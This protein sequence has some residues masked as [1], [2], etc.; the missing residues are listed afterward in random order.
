VEQLGTLNPDILALNEISVPLQTGRWLQRE[1]KKR[2]GLTYAL[3]QQTKSSGWSMDEAQGLLTRFPIVETGNLD[4]LSR[5]RVAQ[6]TRLEIE[7]TNVDVYVTHLHHVMEEDGLRQYQVQ[8]LFE[9]V[10]GRRDA[11]AQIVCG[12]FNATPDA[13]SIKLVPKTFRPVQT[14]ATFPT[15]LTASDGVASEEGTPRLAFCLDY[16][17]ISEELAVQNTG[18]CFDQPN[19]GDP[20]LWPSDHVG[21]WAD[22][23]FR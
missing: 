14:S 1:T 15:G 13:T 10:K 16:I 6:V 2:L 20:T 22:L 11:D 7:G 23:E 3:I 21:V 8:R 9:W 4:Y 19:P 18:C 5:G 17:W 12:D